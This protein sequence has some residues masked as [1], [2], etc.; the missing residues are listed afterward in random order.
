MLSTFKAFSSTIRVLIPSSA[1]FADALSATFSLSTLAT[2][3]WVPADNIDL[4]TPS[5]IPRSAAARAVSAGTESGS[6]IRRDP[7]SQSS[8]FR[9]E[10]VA[11]P[12]P[13]NGEPQY[14]QATRSGAFDLPHREH[15]TNSSGVKPMGSS[16]IRSSEVIVVRISDRNDFIITGTLLLDRGH[17][18]MQTG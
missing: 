7:A 10:T 14:K 11:S 3:K 9:N 5:S 4:R 18:T 15:R 6:A 17:R 12:R 8:S 13:A 16:V 1:S 2:G